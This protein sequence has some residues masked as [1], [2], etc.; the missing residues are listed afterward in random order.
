MSALTAS[1]LITIGSPIINRY[2]L[3]MIC[4]L[5][6]AGN[7]INMYIF[8]RPNLRQNTCVLYLL[9]TSFLNIITL[10]FGA[11]I[12]CLSSYNIDLTYKSPIFCKIRFYLT[13]A[14]QSASL[15]LLVFACIDR[16]LCSSTNIQYRRW[17]TR[18]NTYRVIMC[19]FIFTA[20]SYL[21]ICHCFD[22]SIVTNG[23]CTIRDQTC[24]FVDTVSFIL[25]NSFLPPSLMLAFGIA[26]LK[27]IKRSRRRIEDIFTCTMPMKKINRRDKQLISIL[28]LQ[29]MLNNIISILLLNILSNVSRLH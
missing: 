27:N 5:G 11:F 16:Y 19:I 18:Q 20:I 24:S 25:F 8:S 6:F 7:T 12:R 1:Q 28:L 26:M 15:W 29:V 23:I 2:A 14:S 10:I 9:S 3:L 22:A 13:Y 21:Q 17:L 4:I